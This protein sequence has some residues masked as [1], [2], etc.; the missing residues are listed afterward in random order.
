MMPTRHSSVAFCIV[1][2]ACGSTDDTNH[3]ASGS[4]QF[5]TIGGVVHVRNEGGG[6][7]RTEDA[8]VVRRT[9]QIGSMAGSAEESLSSAVVSTIPGPA[10]QTF[11]LDYVASRVL[12]FDEDG[13]FIREVGRR[14]EGPGEFRAPTGMTIDDEGRLWVAD[15]FGPRYTAFAPDGGLEGIY[16]RPIRATLARQQQMYLGP[17]G[18]I[19]DVGV[20]SSGGGGQALVFTRTNPVDEAVDTAWI[21][22]MPR[23]GSVGT[24]PVPPRSAFAQVVRHYLESLVWTL[25][26]K[27]S[28]WVAP[29]GGAQLINLTPE[30]DTLRVVHVS[31][32]PRALTDDD[33]NLV[34]EAVRE[35]G[36][37]RSAL[38]IVPDAIQFMRVT[39]DGHLLVFV[40][41]DAAGAASTVEVYDPEGRYLGVIDLGFEVPELGVAC[42]RGDTLVAPM[43]GPLETTFVIQAVFERP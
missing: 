17:D 22:E 35:T 6:L 43:I 27:G 19:L 32:R 28:L 38:N 7:W 41:Q 9:L 37:S 2:A 4:V 14:G 34:D 15:A 33:V 31:H 42:V 24:Q 18:R 23:R 39:G 20:R 36:I 3:P 30:G 12:E 26:A 10:G 40:K 8:W 1:L 5:D 29:T 13:Q 16:R 21:V 11:V 25:G